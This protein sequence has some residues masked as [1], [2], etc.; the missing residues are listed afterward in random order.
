MM[1][2]V[3]RLFLSCLAAAL[4]TSIAG[5]ASTPGQCDPSK[6]DFFNNAGCLVSGSYAERKRGL[7]S[8]LASEQS[9]NESFRILLADLKAE[10]A[11]VK[12]TL[13][14]RQAAYARVDA[15][16]RNLR[17]SLSKEMRKSPALRS[18][19]QQIDA[20]VKERKRADSGGDAAKK[21]A[22][23]ESLQ[24]QVTQLERELE[25]GVY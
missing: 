17:S 12:S 21:S 10:Q 13:R 25:A 3:H 15:A 14:T 11:E 1:Y 6:A 2:R 7:E 24:R 18:R 22:T 9:R 4:A 19:V 16:W 5:C 8:E 20:E 23:R